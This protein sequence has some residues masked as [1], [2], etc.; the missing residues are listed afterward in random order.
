[1]APLPE[2]SIAALC[3]QYAVLLLD[4]YGVLVD[5]SGPLPGAGALLH[6]LNETQKLYWILTNDASK[7]PQTLARRYAAYGFPV[8]PDRF[9]TSGDVLA[10]YF[11]AHGLTGSRS[12]VLGPEDTVRYVEQAGGRP[13]SPGEDFDV[14]VVGDVDGFPLRET[15]DRLITALFHKLDRG[16]R[17]H[18]LLP[19]PDLI[20]PVAN[21]RFGMAS[22]S[23]ALLLEAALR[24][25][26]PGRP[27][28]RFVP[29]GK[30]DTALFAEAAR[31]SGTRNMIMIGDQ[32]ETDMRG[33]HA[34]GIDSALVTTGLTVSPAPLS[35]SARPTY[36]LRSL[37]P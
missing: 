4:A 15:I 22:G 7:L 17:V 35:G 18:L 16:D 5:E 10:P 13:V 37:S 8:G 33:A 12:V 20:Y 6:H 26:F 36:I 21:G 34:F 3:A 25:R 31:R 2:T 30:P 29:L 24:L 14:I 11:A 32:L 9:L 1:M 23:L 27:D 28:F 19:N